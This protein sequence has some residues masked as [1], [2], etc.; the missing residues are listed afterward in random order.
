MLAA[1]ED[2]VMTE[3]PSDDPA[4]VGDGVRLLSA[5]VDRLLGERPETIESQGRQHL[6]LRGTAARSTPS[7]RPRRCRSTLATRWASDLGLPQ[8]AAAAV[9]GASD[10]NFTA[11]LG[12]PTLDGLGAVGDHAHGEGEYILTSAMPE[13][14]ALVATLIDHLP[15]R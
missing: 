11:A 10:G 7:R 8:P 5:M 13:G 4:R 6:R 12:V 1:L 14:A 2:L 9:G 15:E 3:T